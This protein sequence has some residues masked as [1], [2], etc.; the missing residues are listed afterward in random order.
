MKFL[1]LVLDSDDPKD[2]A[3]LVAAANTLVNKLLFI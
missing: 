1:I 2:Y 3:M